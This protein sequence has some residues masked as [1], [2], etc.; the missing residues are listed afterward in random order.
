MFIS[1]TKQDY[2]TIKKMFPATMKNDPILKHVYYDATNQKIV[3]CNNTILR[4]E[5]IDL[6]KASL[7]FS[8]EEFTKN[9]ETDTIKINCKSESKDLFYPEYKMLISKVNSNT[10]ANFPISINLEQI[11]LFYK[12]LPKHTS[13][14][15][16]QTSKEKQ[17]MPVKIY[18][19]SNKTFLGLIQPLLI[20]DNYTMTE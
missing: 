2:F 1:I 4:L 8:K 7:F 20:N 9:I 5:S 18:D 12:T 6:G 3:A 15:F 14:I 10:I 13:I 19:A 16:V 17:N 11:T